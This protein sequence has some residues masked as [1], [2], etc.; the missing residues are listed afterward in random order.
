MPRHNTHVRK[1]ENY[2]SSRVCVTNCDRFCAA[3][4]SN[5]LIGERVSLKRLNSVSNDCD[6]I[7]LFYIYII[8]LFTLFRGP[9]SYFSLNLKLYILF[10]FFL[11]DISRG[12][13]QQ[14][15][16]ICWN[17]AVFCYIGSIIHFFFFKSKQKLPRY[18]DDFHARLNTEYYVSVCIIEM[19]ENTK[20]ITNRKLLIDTLSPPVT[21]P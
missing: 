1:R 18:S 9:L 2:Y 11:N 15:I 8:F 19:T 20:R 10:S 6:K 17:F 5:R 7:S 4:K 16:F 3:I 13:D 21:R 14:V 12:T